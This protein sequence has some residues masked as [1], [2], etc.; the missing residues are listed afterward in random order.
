MEDNIR[1]RIIDLYQ[2]YNESNEDRLA[3]RS[4]GVAARLETELEE[5]Q[6]TL[7]SLL[8]DRVM[9]FQSGYYA[10]NPPH[11]WKENKKDP[12]KLK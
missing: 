9:F 12:N 1:Q 2:E 4:Y 10:L 7:R 8:D 3:L 5:T 6:I 11:L